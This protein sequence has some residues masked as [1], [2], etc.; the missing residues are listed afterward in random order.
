MEPEKGEKMMVGDSGEEEGEGEV[1][2]MIVDECAMKDEYSAW[3]MAMWCM[4]AEDSE[5]RYGCWK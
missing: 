4:A 3:R 1:F 5:N 2:D